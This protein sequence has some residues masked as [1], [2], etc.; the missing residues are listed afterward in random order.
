MFVA[1]DVATG[2]EYA[3]KVSLLSAVSIISN[4]CIVL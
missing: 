4:P 3:L 1:Q 2:E